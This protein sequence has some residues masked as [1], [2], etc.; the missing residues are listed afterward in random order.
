MGKVLKSISRVFLIF[1]KNPVN[2]IFALTTLFFVLKVYVFAGGLI[3]KMFLF[4]IL[5]VWFLWFLAK[6]VLI[7]LLLLLIAGSGGYLYFSYNQKLKAECEQSGGV[8]NGNTKVC[9]EKV[10]LTDRIKKMWN[11]FTTQ[12]EE[13]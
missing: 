7:L 10:T 2:T 11:N 12:T 13:K 1:A 9:E 5:G 4:G 3:D 6:H 8:W